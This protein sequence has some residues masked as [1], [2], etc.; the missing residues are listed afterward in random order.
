MSR[1]I[2]CRGRRVDNGEWVY[3][4][5]VTLHYP[6]KTLHIACEGSFTDWSGT[7]FYEVDPK[8]VGQFTGLK[9]HNGFEIYSGDILS[10]EHRNIYL[11]VWSERHASFGLNKKGW[12]FMHYFG[13]AIEADE[14]ERIGNSFENPELI[15]G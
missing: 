6:A 3:G 2:K 8:T 7:R 10:D 12:A 13:E 15:K 5:L 11:V 9:D 4:D 1:E 14:V